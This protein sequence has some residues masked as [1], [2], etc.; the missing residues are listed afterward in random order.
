[1]SKRSVFSVPDLDEFLESQDRAER[2]TEMFTSIRNVLRTPACDDVYVSS[3]V[4]TAEL[5]PST[6]VATLEF[7]YRPTDVPMLSHGLVHTYTYDYSAFF[8]P[9]VPTHMDNVCI[10]ALLRDS[11]FTRSLENTKCIHHSTGKVIEIGSK[12]FYFNAV[13]IGL[14]EMS[15][16]NLR[17]VTEK[18]TDTCR[19]RI[20]ANTKKTTAFITYAYLTYNDRLIP[21]VMMM[22]ISSKVNGDQVDLTAHIEDREDVSTE[23]H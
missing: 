3:L 20:I 14:K 18:L 15:A 22:A 8:G 11:R 9:M 17:L 21:E 23:L 1:M 13:A 12:D 10:D 7:D 19:E 2:L 4:N 5:S 6:I 16:L